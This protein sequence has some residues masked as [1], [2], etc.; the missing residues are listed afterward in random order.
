M[1]VH[2]FALLM[3]KTS[4]NLN[5]PASINVF[6]IPIILDRIYYKKILFVSIRSNK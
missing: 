6:S 1:T 5:L 4:L 3:A 2:L